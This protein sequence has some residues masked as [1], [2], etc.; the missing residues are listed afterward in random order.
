[1][2]KSHL[3]QAIGNHILSQAPSQQVYYI[4][5]EDFTNEMV[6]A[7]RTD[8]IAARKIPESVRDAA[9]GRCTFLTGKDRTQVELSLTLDYFLM[10]K[11]A[12]YSSG[13]TV[14]RYSQ[15]E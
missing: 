11:S 9:A 8:A 7:F 5:A 14:P 15:N 4:T 1:M 2:G 10:R 6:Q 12:S 13:V 3:S